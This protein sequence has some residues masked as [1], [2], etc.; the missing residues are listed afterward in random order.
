MSVASVGTTSEVFQ[1]LSETD[2]KS[3]RLR[4]IRR[5]QLI[6]QIS[7]LA[8][9]DDLDQAGLTALLKDSY[10]QGFDAIKRE[11]LGE[12]DSL[13]HDGLGAAEKRSYLMDQIIRLAVYGITEHLFPNGN[14][15]DGERV[16]IIAT[17]GY[18]RS[19]LAPYS[20]IDLLF[21]IPH[22]HVAWTETVIE[23]LLYLL[24]DLGL[25]IGHAVRT[26]EECSRLA[27]SDLSIR[28]AFLESRLIDGD[29]QLFT[30]ARR[31]YLATVMKG[32]KLDFINA[33]LE[34]RDERHKKL[35]ESRFV[36]EPNIKDGKGGLRDLHTLWWI[37]RF[38]DGAD[39]IS[40]LGQSGILS[41]GEFRRFT[42]AHRFL[43][44][45]RVGMHFLSGRAEERLGFDL[46]KDLATLLGYREGTGQS[47]VE[48]FMK[49]YFLVAKDVGDLTRAYCTGLEARQK[50]DPL[51]TRMTGRRK[52]LGPFVVVNGRLSV[53]EPTM[54]RDEP[55]LMVRIFKDAH[56]YD[57]DIHP[58][59][60]RAMKHYLK[61][62]D[63]IRDDKRA[64]ADFL[65]LMTAPENNERWL[66]RMN[67]A[68][69]LGRFVPDFGRVVAQMQFD[70]YHHYTVDEHTIRAVGLL[71]KLEAGT[72]P[73]L[74]D[75]E[76]DVMGKIN[77]RDVLY[78]AVFLHD[79]A[80]G[81]GGDHSILGAEVAQEFGP[82]LGF[83]EGETETIAWL[84]RYHLLMSATAFKRDLSD[85]KTVRDFV[86][87]VSSPERLRLLYVLTIVDIKAVGPGTWNG[88]KGQL[89]RELY[90]QAEERLM[91][92]HTR[93][94][95]EER[96]KLRQDAVLALLKAE[97]QSWTKRRFQS[98]LK[99]YTDAY[100]LA[101]DEDML[102]QNAL[103]VR[104]F[105]KAVKEGAEPLLISARPDP[106]SDA[107]MVTIITP[108][109]AGIFARLTGAFA[110]VGASIEAAKIHTTKDGLAVDNF[111]VQLAEGVSFSEPKRLDNLYNAA[112]QSLTGQIKLKQALKQ[113]PIDNPGIKEFRIAPFVVIDNKASNRSTVIEVN[114]RDRPGLL[115]DLVSVFFHHKISIFSAHI[116]T[117]G[118][119]A[120]DVFYVRD[121]V[122]QKI[123]NKTRLNALR[124]K[125]MAA[126]AVRDD[127]PLV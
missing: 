107:D 84:V 32:S 73:E 43:W 6:K 59:A 46:Q 54:F 123:T 33:K 4:V 23:S 92:G 110:M 60:I 12:L 126:A 95:R 61:K 29:K 109:H 127:D 53:E 39:T 117:Y 112:L 56:K 57:L 24:W 47:H 122:G 16:A 99:R 34:E 31:L 37:A 22:K 68:G 70:M 51:I 115:F 82:R 106:L 9:E 103:Q 91:V 44:T 81:R 65:Q 100:W 52:K 13:K 41:P 86:E 75:F 71:S 72:D 69:V 49:H 25:K 55:T 111:I 96:V 14:R 5:G 27:A 48:R 19:T 28:T 93:L 105:E 79:I 76:R 3:W 8:S 7:E 89:L 121:L 67:E 66:R 98:Y 80:K 77:A 50:K 40:D 10:F 63:T 108:D 85:T 101:E 21:V 1:E 17:G 116:A 125:L 62:V 30:K 119:R 64:N 104:D 20:D 120:V 42:A 114:G 87:T 35:G 15:T 90:E 2:A 58:D 118:E 102:A 74:G 83:S 26:P 11:F 45:V 113:K 38:S 78:V 18:G 88:W 94:N 97:D 124:L 36:V